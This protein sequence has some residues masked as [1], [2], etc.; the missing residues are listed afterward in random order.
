MFA[1]N[2]KAQDLRTL[3]VTVVPQSLADENIS[4][5]RI[6]RTVKVDI[7]IQKKL[8][9]A[10]T[11]EIDALVRLAEEVITFFRLKGLADGKCICTK[12]EIPA[13]FVPEHIH[14]SR[15]FTSVITLIFRVL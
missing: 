12:M 11:E 4:R 14:E 8:D 7:G 1:P 13:V 5:D 2:F 10:T 15:I 6:A 3:H 9:S